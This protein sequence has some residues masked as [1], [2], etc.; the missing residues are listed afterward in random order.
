MTDDPVIRETHTDSG[1]LPEGAVGIDAGMTLTKLARATAGGIVFEARPSRGGESDLVAGARV[2]GVTGALAGPMPEGAHVAN[3]IEAA[4]R[5]VTALTAGAGDGEFL[6]ALLGTGTAF[7][8]V[9]GAACQHLGGT[10]LG[11]GSFAGIA[12]RVDPALTYTAMLEGAAR[13]DRTRVDTMIADVYPEGIG[14]IGPALTAAH[15]TRAGEGSLD[16]FLAG[17]LNLH[18]ENIAQ[19]AGGRA[20]MA[21]VSRIVIAGGFAHGNP[22]LVASFTS[23][24]G[25]FGMSVEVRAA[26]R[27]RR[28][29]RGRA[30]GGGSAVMFPS[31]AA[32]LQAQGVDAPEQTLAHNGYSGARISRIEQGDRAYVLKRLSLAENWL[33]RLTG[34][35]RCREAVFAASPLPAKLPTGIRAP[36][37]AAARDGEGYAVLMDDLSAALLPDDGLALAANHGSLPAT[38]RR[39]SRLGLGT[40]VRR[41]RHPLVRHRRTP[42]AHCLPRTA[43]CSAAKI[44]ISARQLSTVGTRSGAPRLRPLLVSSARC[45]MIR[46]R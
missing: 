33:M 19:I 38:G 23:M 46:R 9:R 1:L 18:A 13:G 21:K 40:T 39:A 5:G 29:A 42:D 25:L 43:S 6:L 8:A 12:R 26:S 45:R 44:L 30:N 7:A 20:L 22:A 24:S 17:L 32:M 3:E 2:V 15:L 27:I 10:P 16:D 41:H 11:G 36:Y 35:Y 31:V 34:D 37:V 14:R 28:R 4:A